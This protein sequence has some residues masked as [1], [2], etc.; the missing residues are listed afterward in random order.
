MPAKH[1]VDMDIKMVKMRK[2]IVATFDPNFIRVRC[3]YCTDKPG[4]SCW[5][6]PK[7]DYPTLKDVEEYMRINKIYRTC[8]VCEKPFQ[9]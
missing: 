5:D 4:L 1:C 3:Q 2:R 6:Y 7:K 8:G 9:L